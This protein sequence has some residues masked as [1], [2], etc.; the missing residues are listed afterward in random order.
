MDEHG[1]FNFGPNASHM[2][3]AV[4]HQ[5]VIIVEV[6]ENMPVCL[7]GFENVVHISKV[8]MIVEGQQSSNRRDGRRRSCH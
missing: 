3:Q 7:G 6:N 8:D 5:K 4:R 1:Y 2:A